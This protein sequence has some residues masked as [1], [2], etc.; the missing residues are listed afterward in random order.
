MLPFIFKKLIGLLFMPLSL[1]LVFLLAGIIMLLFTRKQIAARIFLITGC[2]LLL[3]FSYGFLLYWPLEKLE[4]EYPPF[5]I[6]SSGRDCRWIVV[7]AGDQDESVVRLVEGVRIHRAIYG[8]KL[9]VSGGR[10]FNPVSAAEKMA[11]MA[12]GLGVHP[13]DIVLEDL[14]KD[15]KDEARIIRDMVRQ[16]PFVLV[17]SAYHMPRSMALF[18]AQGLNPV[19]APTQYFTSGDNNPNP[20]MFFP[21]AG[22]VYT[23]EI[24][25]HEILGL[26]AA[27]IMGQI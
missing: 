17:T 18:Q 6:R 27:G 22:N 1:V 15:T 8:S 4:S 23:A 11:H 21:N 24:V 13:E 10:I 9:I 19:P 26:I 25:V 20:W 7:L 2:L 12:M 16:D 3:I 5:D 14:S